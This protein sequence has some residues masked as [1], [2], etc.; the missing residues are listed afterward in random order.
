LC[1]LFVEICTGS[2]YPLICACGKELKNRKNAYKHFKR[3]PE[4]KILL[5]ERPTE[6][7]KPENPENLL[8]RMFQDLQLTDIEL[9]KIEEIK[10][11]K[12][13]LV[14]HEIGIIN[15]ETRTSI[16]DFYD[17]FNFATKADAEAWLASLPTVQDL[18]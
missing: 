6:I 15:Y 17:A 18:K 7:T 2:K 8:T 10:W 1:L 13:P 11:N 14:S 9:M 4:C 16:L 3:F 12:N 5:D